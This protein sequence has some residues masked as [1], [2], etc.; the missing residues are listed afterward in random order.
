M[1]KDIT[2]WYSLIG[3]ITKAIPSPRLL[4]RHRQEQAT[5][6]VCT[7]Y[8]SIVC[9]VQCVVLCELHCSSLSNLLERLEREGDYDEVILIPV[10]GILRCQ[11][12]LLGF[13]CHRFLPGPENYA[14]G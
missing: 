6:V 10:P 7:T 5:Y 2:K 1:A 12:G 8:R 11:V 3:D 13:A 4:E 9:C 14:L